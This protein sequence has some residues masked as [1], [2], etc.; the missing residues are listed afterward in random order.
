MA[1]FSGSSSW[2][3]SN[4]PWFIWAFREFARYAAVVCNEL[5]P[6]RGLCE[7]GNWTLVFASIGTDGTDGPTDSAGAI[8]DGSTV[9]RA[10][11]KGVDIA[12]YI[13]NNDSYNFFKQLDDLIITGP[14]N[15]NVMD[16]RIMLV[17]DS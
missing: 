17:T 4:S 16:V 3:P 6:I 13:R 11:D 8:A 9:K 7:S 1:T 5:L 14:T 2:C 12:E 15:T 10:S